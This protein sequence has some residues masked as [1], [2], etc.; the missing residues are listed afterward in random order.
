MLLFQV[1]KA[2]SRTFWQN[3]FYQTQVYLGSELWVWM[4]TTDYNTLLRL[5]LWDSG[6]WWQCGATWW[7]NLRQVAA[8]CQKQINLTFCLNNWMQIRQVRESIC[9]PIVHLAM[10][11]SFLRWFGETKN[12]L[13]F[14]WGVLQPFPNLAHQLLLS[15]FVTDDWIPMFIISP[16]PENTLPCKYV[17]RQ[18]LYFYVKNVIVSK[19]FSLLL[20]LLLSW[21]LWQH[22]F[23]EI[24]LIV[25]LSLRIFFAQHARYEEGKT[26]R[27][28]FVHNI[29]RANSWVRKSSFHISRK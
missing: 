28:H 6:W 7:P 11:K 3:Y 8:V 25:I 20:T 22:D 15:V 19:R 1:S 27:R 10:F 4:S 21:L 2:I 5:N 17:L 9:G 18:Q 29:L 13:K 16:P 23:E 26:K 14:F 12:G 24:R